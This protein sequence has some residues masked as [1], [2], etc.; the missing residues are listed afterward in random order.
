MASY[1]D[2]L[3]HKRGELTMVGLHWA[4]SG[5]HEWVRLPGESQRKFINRAQAAAKAEGF[6][7]L[8]FGGAYHTSDAVSFT[9]GEET[10]GRYT[11]ASEN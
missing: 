3:M 11:E 2:T 5:P 9:D 8:T 10:N 1:I 4:R 7:I 6:K